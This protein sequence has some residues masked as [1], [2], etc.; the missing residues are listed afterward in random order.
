M[1]YQGRIRDTIFILKTL[2]TCSFIW[3]LFQAGNDK[4]NKILTPPPPEFRDML[5]C[6]LPHSAA[7]R[8][9]IRETRKKIKKIIGWQVEPTKIILLTVLTDL[10]VPST[11]QRTALL[12]YSEERLQIKFNILDNWEIRKRH[13]REEW[14]GCM[15][16]LIHFPMQIFTDITNVTNKFNGIRATTFSVK[17]VKSAHVMLMT[18]LHYVTHTCSFPNTIIIPSSTLGTNC[19]DIQVR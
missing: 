14:T 4:Y 12:R 1:Q 11:R 19:T 7:W 13:G 9:K 17:T 6:A 10:P 18:S 2:R 15:C 3:D 5:P 8:K 16:S